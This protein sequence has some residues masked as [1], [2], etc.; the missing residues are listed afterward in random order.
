M[1]VYLFCILLHSFLPSPS[2]PPLAPQ[3]R[4]HR[5]GVTS[6]GQNTIRHVGIL[7]TCPDPMLS[8]T[9]L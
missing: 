3:V 4:V 8:F 6:R 5:D 2:S 1:D 7:Q 9:C